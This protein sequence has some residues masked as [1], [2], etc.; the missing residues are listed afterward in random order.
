MINFQFDISEILLE[1]NSISGRGSELKRYILGKLTDNFMHRWEQKVNKELKGTRQEYKKAMFVEYPE[2]GVAIIG[3]TPRESQLALMIEDGASS[4]DMKDGF[5][6]SNKRVTKLGE[7]DEKSKRFTEGGWYLTIPFR[8]ATSEAIGESMAFSG[9][10]TRKVESEVKRQGT[11][12]DL[13]RLPDEY[14]KIMSNPT[15]GTPHKSPIV[16]GMKRIDISSTNKENRSGYFT[17]RRVSDN[18]EDG[19]WQ[20]PGF[21]AK[22]LIDKTIKE[23]PFDTIVKK[24]QLMNF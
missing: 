8:H 2:D 20:H 5:S 12:K 24:W 13:S 23:M 11:L 9:K 17:F 22:G 16:E 21:E 10:M 6:R 18:S 19:S 7:Y 4:W 1:F 15:T 3:L 14:Q